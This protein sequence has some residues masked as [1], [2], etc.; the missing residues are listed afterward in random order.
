MGLRTQ[1]GA[2]SCPVSANRDNKMSQPTMGF[3]DN[4]K[5][6]SAAIGAALS[7]SFAPSKA[8]AQ[9]AVAPETQ[10]P[11]QEQPMV[12]PSQVEHMKRANAPSKGAV[13]L[14]LAKTVATDKRVLMVI[15]AGAAGAIG[16]QAYKKS[17]AKKMGDARSQ[18]S[19]FKDISSIDTSIL[20]ERV[21]N[22]P[23]AKMFKY[24]GDA[25][26]FGVYREP[27]KNKMKDVRDKYVF[28]KPDENKPDLDELTK[29]VQLDIF[30]EDQDEGEKTTPEVEI[31]GDDEGPKTGADRDLEAEL[32]SFNMDDM[33]KEMMQGGAAG[34]ADMDPAMMAAAL[35]AL[36]EQLSELMKGGISKDEVAEVKQSFKDMGIDLEDMF[37]KIDEMEKA[38]LGDAVG[39]EGAQFFKTLRGILDAA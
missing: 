34:P 10:T 27:P 9:T 18:L 31:V 23:G 28:K 25:A 17:E 33:M 24:S 5:K 30:K 13:V 35:P 12:L 2:A 29:A 38:G 7:V 22:R 19:G 21:V 14:D 1:F 8:M 11:A 6:Y 4:F 15:G 37:E 39:A 26:K 32:G 3:R 16:M 36:Q 20:D